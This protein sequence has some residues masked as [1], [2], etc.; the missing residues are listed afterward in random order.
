[1]ER[2]AL[3]PQSDFLKQVAELCNPGR[4]ACDPG[5]WLSKRCAPSVKDLVVLADIKAIA[6]KIHLNSNC[7][8]IKAERF[9]EI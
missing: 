7:T 2:Y 5:T 3:H 6:T 4:A 9:V 1:M 8:E